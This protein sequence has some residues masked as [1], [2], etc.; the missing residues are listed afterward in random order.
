MQQIIYFIQKYKYFLFFLLLEFFALFFT[1]NNNNF[2]KSKFISSANEITGGFYEKTSKISDYFNLKTQNDELIS[3]NEK[4]KNLI[5]K[6]S[7]SLDSTINITVFDTVKYNQKYIYSSAKVYKNSYHLPNN[8]ITINKGTNQGVEK[9]MAV[10]N[11]KG[12]IGITEKT[13]ANYTR[14]QSILNNNSKI[15]ARLK[16]DTHFGSLTWNGKDYNSVQLEDIPRQAIIQIGDTIVTGG[17]SSIFPEGIP[18]G[19]IKNINIENNTNIINIQ[20]FNDMSS[21]GYV[22]VITHLDKQE[23]KSLNE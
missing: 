3:E 9:E 12:I 23:I 21:I 11:S 15:N 18:I 7:S 14:V 17:K 16:N 5:E 1:I 10:I 2:H 6:Y 8:Y 13:S 20:L 22:Y 19:V 4:L